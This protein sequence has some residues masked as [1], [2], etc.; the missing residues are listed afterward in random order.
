M[1]A[2]NNLVELIEDPMPKAES[3]I[4]FSATSGTASELAWARVIRA[5]VAEDSSCDVGDLVLYY[6]KGMPEV[7]LFGL[8]YV[9]VPDAAIALRVPDEHVA[10]KDL[11][12]QVNQK[13]SDLGDDWSEDKETEDAG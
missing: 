8:K 2:D 3:V 1:V 5:G 13:L 4:I 9:V 7:T 11:E 10:S 12:D 6:K